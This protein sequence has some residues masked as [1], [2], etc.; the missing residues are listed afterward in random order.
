MCVGLDAHQNLLTVTILSYHH[1]INSTFQVD[2]RI[3][4]QTNKPLI[5]GGECRR[6]LHILS[7]LSI[8]TVCQ[9]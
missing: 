5:R 6:F 8:S 9:C 7:I 3:L 1:G 2:L 4:L